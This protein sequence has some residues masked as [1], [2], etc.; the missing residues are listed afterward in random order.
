MKQITSKLYVM[1]LGMA[2]GV[3]FDSAYAISDLHSPADADLAQPA[4]E[5]QQKAMNR[6]WTQSA[7]RLTEVVRQ[8][9]RQ[10][11]A[12]KTRKVVSAA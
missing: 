6:N 10:P 12:R 7:V 3:A 11:L 2:S 5:S 4:T 8:L 1:T 9:V